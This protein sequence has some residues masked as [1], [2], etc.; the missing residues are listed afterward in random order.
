[1]CAL[2]PP[3]AYGG[4]R[5]AVLLRPAPLIVYVMTTVNASAS[6]Y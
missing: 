4:K 5:Q 2:H 6:M 3:T 1:M